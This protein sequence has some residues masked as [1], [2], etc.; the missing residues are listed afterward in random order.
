MQSAPT[1]A[2]T[3]PTKLSCASWM[4]EEEEFLIN[5]MKERKSMAGDRGNVKKAA[6]DAATTEL[7]KSFPFRPKTWSACKTKWQNVCTVCYVFSGKVYVY[8]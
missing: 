2:A 3:S 1:P 8:N 4:L 6:W 5:F 7:R